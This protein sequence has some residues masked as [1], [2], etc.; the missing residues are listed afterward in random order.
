M[1]N[2]IKVNSHLVSN[3]KHNHALDKNSKKNSTDYQDDS[4]DDTLPHNNPLSVT[5]TSRT[6]GHKHPSHH[7]MM[8][9]SPS[10]STSSGAS[11]SKAGRN[12][13]FDLKHSLAAIDQWVQQIEEDDE[14]EVDGVK[15][16]N[17]NNEDADNNFVIDNNDVS[18]DE[19][20]IDD[21]SKVSNKPFTVPNKYRNISGSGVNNKNNQMKR[22]TDDIL[23]R[24]DI[25]SIIS[26][27]NMNSNDDA[28]DKHL[29]SNDKMK[30]ERKNSATSSSSVISTTTTNGKNIDNELSW[31]GAVH[32]T[33][34]ELIK[35]LQTSP[36]ESIIRTKEDFRQF[37][38]GF[39]RQEMKELL[40]DAYSSIEDITKRDLKIKK[41]MTIVDSVLHD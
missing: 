34:T 30:V 12:L 7:P 40:R 22:V 3:D 38:S 5:N 37:F 11:S 26:G 16:S 2:K 27:D 33:R 31:G 8:N 1:M 15:I 18:V 32:R 10:A 21:G 29:S 14:D 17:N 9:I 41:R 35:I 24:E 25:I 23:S 6:S 36:K 4:N 19:D 39:Q 13:G 20:D 28:D